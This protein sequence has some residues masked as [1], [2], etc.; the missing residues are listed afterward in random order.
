MGSYNSENILDITIGFAA[1]KKCMFVTN[2]WDSNFIAISLL[3]FPPTD[4]LKMQISSH[5]VSEDVFTVGKPLDD[6][7]SFFH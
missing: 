2:I 7:W 1:G 5:N 4:S 3:N 6:A